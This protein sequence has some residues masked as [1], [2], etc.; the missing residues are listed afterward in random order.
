[1][2]RQLADKYT[3]RRS[4][5]FPEQERLLAESIETAMMLILH[6]NDHMGWLQF[7]RDARQGKRKKK[8][9][10]APALDLEEIDIDQLHAAVEREA[11][12]A[13]AQIVHIAKAEA[14]QFVGQRELA[15]E[16]LDRVWVGLG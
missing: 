13:A 2:A 7:L 14:A 3:D 16:F 5:I 4:L 12:T 11:T 1:M 10:A 9:V 8:E 6:F 15:V